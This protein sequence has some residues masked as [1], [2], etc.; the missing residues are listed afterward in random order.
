MPGIEKIKMKAR[1]YISIILIFAANTLFAQLK[2]TASVNST[3]VGTGEPFEVTFAINGNGGD[4]T[5]PNFRG[6]QVV[7]G[8]NESTSMESVNGNTSVSISYGYELV[9]VKEGSFTIGPAA[10][11]VN[12]HK[13]TSNPLKITV[14]KGRPV[15]QSSQAQSVPQGNTGTVNTSDLS[16]LVFIKAVVD[17]TDVYEGQQISLTYK[18]YTRVGIEQSA[19]DVAPSLNGFWS[20]DIKA[21][22]QQIPF[23]QEVYKRQQYQVAE[24]KK[25]IL[26]PQHT[27]NLTVDPLG[28]TLVLRVPV[29]N[30]DDLFD[31]MFGGEREVKYEAKSPPVTIHVKPLPDAGKPDT[32]SGAVGKFSVESSIDKT[33]VKANDALNY[34][35]TIKGE[36]NLKLLQA[37]VTN[38]PADFEKYDPKV[39]DT[40]TENENGMSG[41]RTYTYLLIPRHQGDFTIDPLKFSYFNPETGRYYTVETKAFHIKVNKGTSQSN[42]T[43]F[44]DEN[45]QDVKML[46][47]D[48]RYIKTG[49]EGLSKP[50][51][52]FFGSFYLLLLIGPV[53]AFAAWRYRNWLVK[54]NSDIVQVKSR[55]AGK[56]AAKHLASAQQQL[57]AHNSKT[58]YENVFRGLY[59]YLSDKLNIQYAGLDR[60]TI[61]ASLKARSVSDEVVTRLL[62]T[63]DLCE[64]ARYA[65]VTHISENEVFDKAK[66][67]INDIEDEI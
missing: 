5:P 23:H 6:F 63:L 11:V 58:F 53:T 47:K 29:S 56:V 50:G 66:G 18:L 62:D 41:A 59:G 36:G 52:G 37:P 38:F 44:S 39:T 48:I 14:V 24:V 3:S 19:P 42:V 51:G 49:S 22:Q 21:P 43:D 35:L 2:L 7:G 1:Y 45:K 16:K 34:K 40:I 32:F 64:M 17:K 10:I 31:Q 26:F 27:G 55:R 8:P 57:L 61:A 33:E 13:L 9:A 67:I 28:I 30:G 4:F 54:T 60:E 46:S 25:T 15:Q 20:E 12:G 65:P